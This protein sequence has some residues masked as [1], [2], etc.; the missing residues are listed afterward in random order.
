MYPELTRNYV[1][2]TLHWN[3]REEAGYNLKR[4]HPCWGYSKNWLESIRP[5][6]VEGSTSRGSWALL[7]AHYSTLASKWHA[8]WHHSFETNHKRP[9]NEWWSNFWKSPPL[10]W[11]S[12]NNHPTH[13]PMKLPSPIKAHHSQISGA[14]SGLL[15][16]TPFCLWNV[17]LP[18]CSLLMR[19]P[20]L[21]LLKNLLLSYHFASW[22]I[23]SVLRWKNLNFSSSWDQV[24]DFN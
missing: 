3:R 18:G 12:W 23:P 19:Q 8:H 15:R 14:L 16:W 9:K 2:L 20:T 17:Q 10:P 5:K 22:W 11:S 6:M 13:Q 21:C 4:V 1:D 24:C 7:G